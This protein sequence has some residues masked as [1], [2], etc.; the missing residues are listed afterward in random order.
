MQMEI[1]NGNFLKLVLYRKFVQ[2]CTKF[3]ATSCEYPLYVLKDA[4]CTQAG[5][6]YTL[7]IS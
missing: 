5:N 7:T 4:R 1:F 2:M 3:V 6:Q